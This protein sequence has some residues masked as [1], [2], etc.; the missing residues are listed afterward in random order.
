MRMKN[1]R[2]T[3]RWAVAAFALI[4]LH[5]AD[6]R[7]ADALIVDAAFPGGNIIV[8]KIE[9]DDVYV[10]QDLRDT[11]GSWFYWHFRIC[12]A[13]GRTLKF[14]FTQGKVLGPLGPCYSLDRGLTW[15]WL[16]SKRSN[17][18]D[19]PPNEGFVFRFP[20]DTQDVRFCLSIPYLQANLERFLQ[21]HSGDPALK[22]DVLC[23]TT[24][25]RSA[26]VL[27]LGRMDG[28]P[29]YR[30]AFTCR[31][32][33]CESTASYVLE[34]FCEA[35]LAD[36]PTGRWFRDRTAIVAVPFVDKDGVE[37]G[38][39]GK[40]RKPHDHN[41]DYTGEPIYPTVAAIKRLL[42]AW[43]DG[44]LDVAL[45]LH[46]PSLGDQLIQFVGGP[47]EDIW[48]RTLALS[49]T[50]ETHQRS[51]LRHNSQRNLPF[52]TGWNKGPSHAGAKFAAWA[53]KLPNVLIGATIEFPYSQVSDTPVTVDAVRM[54]GGDLADAL[55]LYLQ[56]NQAR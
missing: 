53:R 1:N 23:K 42:P 49:Q 26:E 28:K 15:Q 2:S 39:Q 21:R 7:A 43:S 20:S 51:P 5:A 14:H 11:A 22:A 27:Y 17:T 12:G 52:G 16:G 18:A 45:D 35:V 44:K 47:Q 55:R 6:G 50:I 38:D 24:A 9:G 46:C 8:D 32:H 13:A 56:E 30:L 34:G 33:A 25:G 19:T 31:H 37:A 10:R 54:W 36:T 41:R 40:G 48:Q 3:L 29:S 4:G